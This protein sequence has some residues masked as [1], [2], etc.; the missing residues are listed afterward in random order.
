MKYKEMV[1]NIINILE[2]EGE[3]QKSKILKEVIKTSDTGIEGLEGKGGWKKGDSLFTYVVNKEG[4][5]EVETWGMKYEATL[6]TETKN[7]R[8]RKIGNIAIPDDIDFSKDLEDEKIFGEFISGEE[9][10]EPVY[11]EDLET[12]KVEYKKENNELKKIAPKLTEDSVILFKPEP[13]LDKEG[14]VFKGYYDK[15]T[16]EFILDENGEEILYNTYISDKQFVKEKY[17]VEVLKRNK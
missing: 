4:E 15:K 3:I 1:D 2:K 10:G 16:G 9:I 8:E 7:G 17:G 14:N 12:F 6:S 5:L 13:L 11:G